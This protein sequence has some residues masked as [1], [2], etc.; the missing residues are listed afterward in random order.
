MSDEA[1]GQQV[2][3]DPSSKPDGGD[4]EYED[5]RGI[6]YDPN[7]DPLLAQAEKLPAYIKG[8]DGDASHVHDVDGEGG[9]PEA[10][11]DG[12]GYTPPDPSTFTGD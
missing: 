10:M 5:R 6:E 3:P 7:N 4:R 8:A 1:G 12:F 9:D 11:E 2:E